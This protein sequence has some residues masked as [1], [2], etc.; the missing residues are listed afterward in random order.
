MSEGRDDDDAPRPK[1]RVAIEIETIRARPGSSRPEAGPSTP[2]TSPPS[3][4]P[5]S[6]PIAPPTAPPPSPR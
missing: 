2:R 4:E 5:S 6:R 1:R 3:S